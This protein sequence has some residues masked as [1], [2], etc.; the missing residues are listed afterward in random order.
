MG[1]CTECGRNAGLLMSVCDDCTRRERDAV[2]ARRRDAAA[3][4]TAPYADLKC[5]GCGGAMQ[6]FG[7]VP[8]RTGGSSGGWHMVFG[9]LADAGESLIVLDLLRCRDCRR[10]EFYD[11]DLKLGA[12]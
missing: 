7:K 2:E 11:L 12:L 5:A 10:V 9:E 3:A 8:L 4:R 1:Q 6:S